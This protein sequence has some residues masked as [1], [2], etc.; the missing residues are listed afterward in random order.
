MAGVLFAFFMRRWERRWPGY[1]FAAKAGPTER[2][3]FGLLRFASFGLRAVL[4]FVTGG[5]Q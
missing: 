5:V 1:A 3:S 4:N 2:E